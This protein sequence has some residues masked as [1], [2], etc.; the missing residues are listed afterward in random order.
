MVSSLYRL[1]QPVEFSAQF[2]K[3]LMCGLKEAFVCKRTCFE[4]DVEMIHGFIAGGL[5]IGQEAD[6][7]LFVSS[8]PIPLD[9]VR[10]HRFDG[11]PDL[12]S[13][14]VQFMPW[15]HVENHL[16]DFG[17][18]PL[19]QLPDLEFAIAHDLACR[20][21]SNFPP[22]STIQGWVG[23]SSIEHRA[24]SINALPLYLRQSA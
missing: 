24:S 2:V 18:K 7:F 19:R 11:S 13:F 23:G 3:E 22:G 8:S 1:E 16:V 12:A 9:N 6:E 15:E 14:F 5:S 21:T 10:S 20:S 4:K 17:R